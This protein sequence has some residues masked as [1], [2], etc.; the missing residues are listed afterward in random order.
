[1][2]DAIDYPALVRAALTAMV[3]QLLERAAA[4]GLP[5]EHHFYLSFRTDAEGVEIPP[6][7]R[8]RH[9]REM[10]VVLQHQFWGLQVDDAGFSVTLRFSGTPARVAVP[11]QALTAFADP[12]VPVGL[13]LAPADEEADA[14]PAADVPAGAEPTAS[15]TVPA[16]GGADSG[17]A[18]AANVVAFRPRRPESE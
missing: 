8:Q 7:L 9:P 15:A 5:G 12:S 16:P 17:A 11:W 6:A 4:E 2:A 13:R 10:I 14:A 18:P 1:M 3:R